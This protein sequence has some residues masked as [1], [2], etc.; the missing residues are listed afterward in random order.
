MARIKRFGRLILAFWASPWLAGLAALAVYITLS[1]M[2]GSPFRESHLGYF[3]YLADAFLHGQLHLRLQ[4]EVLHDLVMYKGNIYLYW[5]PFPAIL[6]MPFVALF[7]VHMS[8]VFFVTILGALNVS[9]L[10]LLLAQLDRKK[11]LVLDAPR[12]GLLVLFFALGSVLFPMA[13][14]G[15]VWEMSQ[16]VGSLCV[17]LAYLAAVSFRGGWAF[18]L[19]GLA[20]G[21][22]LATRNHLL[23][24]G[25]WPAYYLLSSH[26]RE[27]RGRQATNTLL[28]LM[29]VILIV[30][31]LAWYNWAR[32]GSPTDMGISY[33][34][35]DEVFRA[36]FAKYGYFNLHYLPVNIYYQYIFYPFPWRPESPMG[37]S[38]FL[39]SPV[40]IGMFWGIARGKPRLPVLFLVLSILITNI[41]IL[42]LMGTGWSQ[43]GPRY[44]L[45]FH[46]PMIMLCA[47]GIKRW[48]LWLAGALVFFSCAQYFYGVIIS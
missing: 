30:A 1:R 15:Q 41:P 3:P 6:L 43:V 23:F 21:G 14:N 39:L 8:D 38:L 27:D 18:L 11:V 2:W 9:M 4:P 12:R 20:F 16:L 31:G 40:L 22:A 25:V 10:A 32:F 45:D 37:G 7:G 44:T 42:L 35:M 33:H 34:E 13:L 36:D 28:G 26:T 17:I 5:A 47:M 48:P 46:V 24:T 19:T 29:P